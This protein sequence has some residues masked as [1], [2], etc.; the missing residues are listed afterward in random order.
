EYDQTNA[1]ASIWL[2]K[3]VGRRA[4][5]EGRYR[6]EKIEVDV[7]SDVP[8]GSE[9]EEEEGTYTRSALSINYIY[10]SR[11][12]N[13]LPR[14]GEKIDVGVTLAGGVLGGDVDTY[15]VTGAGTKHWNLSWDTILTARGSF[16]VVDEYGGDGTAPIFERQFLGGS[17]DLRGFE[18]RDLGPRDPVTNEVIGGG[19]SAFVSLE[20]TFPITERVRGAV[21][22]DT[23]FVNVD[24]WDFGGGDLA[25]DAGLG[26][27]MD[28]PIGPLAV[29]YAIPLSTPD[30]EAD[31]GGQFNFYLNYQY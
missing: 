6:F 3:Q 29:D 10:D 26:L 22:Y 15:T 20:L 16:S 23:G 17:R 13:K 30:D 11:D 25:S 14:K 28:L 7:E 5:I 27:R 31:N 8:P 21:F 2:G 1:G 4:R 12:S 9:F 24:S 19:T 18:Y